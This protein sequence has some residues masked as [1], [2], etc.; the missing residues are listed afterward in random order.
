MQAVAKDP[1]GIGYGGAAYGSGARALLVS[2]RPGGK[3]IEPSAANIMT[4]RYPIWRF[5]YIYV[6][7]VLDKNEVHQYL[8]WIRGP[9]GQALVH[10][11]GY[12]P[13]P[14]NLRTG[15][16]PNDKK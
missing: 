1:K 9:E 8:D 13:L 3:G 12:F 11:V 10:E 6:N 5:L 15:S 14:E 2:E 16:V 7:P 4:H